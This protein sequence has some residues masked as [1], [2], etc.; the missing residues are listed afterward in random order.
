MARGDKGVPVPQLEVFR[1]R[2]G[3]SQEELATRAGLTR[4]T[5][6]RLEQGGIA[7]YQTIDKLAKALKTTRERLIR[8]TRMKNPTTPSSAA[9]E[10]VNLP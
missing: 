5:I 4:T 2:A 6:T 10:K 7:R 3:L 8:E 1:K 9:T